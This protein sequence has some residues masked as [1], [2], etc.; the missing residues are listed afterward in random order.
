[1]TEL[2]DAV[3]LQ[4]ELQRR[5]LGTA[6]GARRSG[7]FT[8]FSGRFLGRFG[9]QPGN[10]AEFA[11]DAAYLF[12]YAT[13]L[14]GQRSPTGLSLAAALKNVS[15]KDAGMPKLIA[16]D[17]VIESFNLAMTNPCIDFEGASG[18]LDFNND[19]GEAAS[20]IA[21]W[22]PHAG[23]KTFKPLQTYYQATERT[24]KVPQ[25]GM[26]PWAEGATTCQ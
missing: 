22:C 13:G 26:G 4:P 20:D 11:Y 5:I 6:P 9:E 25:A 21:L 24:L 10:L 8:Q 19:T 2:I 17:A 3:K 14:S 16:G 18:P 15:C 1:V 23:S 7:F 12:A